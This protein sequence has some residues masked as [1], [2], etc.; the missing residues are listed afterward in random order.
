MTPISGA[1]LGSSKI[2]IVFHFEFTTLETSIN[3]MNTFV[4]RLKIQVNLPENPSI[5]LLLGNFFFNKS[6]KKTQ[7]Q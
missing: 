2:F 7:E 5:F 4:M 6:A 1:H 3:F